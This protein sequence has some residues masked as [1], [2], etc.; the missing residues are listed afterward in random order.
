MTDLIRRTRP[1]RPV[2]A[3]R[4][5]STVEG[6]AARVAVHRESGRLVAM[7]EPQLTGDGRVFV[8]VTLLGRHPVRKRLSRRRAAITAA[9]VIPVLAGV[10]WAAYAVAQLVEWLAAHAAVVAGCLLLASLALV[11]LRPNHRATCAGLHCAG[12]RG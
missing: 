9:V 1:A 10:V 3:L 8:D 6:V 4:I 12:C 5:T 11:F 7:T 2:T